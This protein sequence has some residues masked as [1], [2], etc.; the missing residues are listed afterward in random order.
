MLLSRVK[1][2][3]GNSKRP[4]KKLEIKQNLKS[5][6]LKPNNLV[7]PNTC[8]KN[9]LQKHVIRDS[10]KQVRVERKNEGDSK[11]RGRNLFLYSG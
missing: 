3:R 7:T 2:N 1:L 5:H 9:S 4:I 6:D 10:K 11:Q 8:R